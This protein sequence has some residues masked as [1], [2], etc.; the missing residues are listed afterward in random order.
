[1]FSSQGGTFTISNLGMFGV[2]E[3]TAIINPPQCAILA[4]GGGQ[5][6]IDGENGNP[7]TSMRATLSFDRRFI[8][9]ALASDFMSVL[10][11]VI[12][13]PQYMNIGLPP[14]LRI[15]RAL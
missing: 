11:K 7:Y 14:V 10:Q 13:D 15:A 4:V 3:F 9:E 6:E 2:K 8:D 12:E 1:M 5:S